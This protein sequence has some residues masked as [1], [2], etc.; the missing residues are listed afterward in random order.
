MLEGNT[1]KLSNGKI[2]KI[3][4]LNATR[5]LLDTSNVAYLKS[6]KDENDNYINIVSLEDKFT[7]RRGD[8]I[9][10]LVGNVISEYEAKYIIVEDKGKSIIIYSALPTKTSVFLLPVLRK[11]Q[12]HLKTDT[13]F[14][15]AYLDE[16]YKFLYLM[17]RFTGTE[18]YKEF[19]KIMI[20]DSFCVSHL[21]H[22]PY[23]VVY[24]FK[25]PKEF[26]KDVEFFMEGKYSKFSKALKGRIQKFYGRGNNKHIM[27]IITKDKDLKKQMENHLQIKLPE[28]TELASR[29]D[30]ENEI[31][32]PYVHIRG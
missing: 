9:P 27:D 28:D 17:Y 10:I 31:Y 8:K 16:S 19:E 25:I 11:N 14:V 21:E 7:I 30:I 29:P 2:V 22:G 18:Y 3:H 6:E 20:T 13:Y 15:N 23:H 1:I 26:E 32:I 4:H 24:K 12:V 5:L